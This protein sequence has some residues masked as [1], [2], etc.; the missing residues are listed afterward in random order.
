MCS[1]KV[2]IQ[3]CTPY[4][5]EI[6]LTTTPSHTS[7]DESLT[8]DLSGRIAVLT[9]N[10][11]E[12]RNPLSVPTMHEFIEKL[13]RVSQMDDIGVIVLK[14]T[15]N[16]FCSGHDLREVHTAKLEEERKLFA[17]CSTMMQKIQQIRQ[18]VVASVQ[19]IAAAAGAQLV[20]TC[21]LAIASSVSKYFTPGVKMGLCSSN[22][23]DRGAHRC[24]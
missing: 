18:P 3:V 13:E 6:A 5:L 17:L 20:A 14:S 9:F 7:A 16:V 4:L 11:P 22:V 19:G 1:H 23:D 24:P 2:D 12:R 10:R 8:L 15:G 21:D